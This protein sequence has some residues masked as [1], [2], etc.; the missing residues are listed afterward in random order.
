MKKHHSLTRIVL[1]LSL[2]LL[3]YATPY[4]GGSG[5]AEDPYQI[6]TPEQM[7]AIG[8]NNID[9]SQHFIL[10]EDIDMSAYTGSDY[11][12][13]GNSSTKFTGT[14]DG[15]GHVILNLTYESVGFE[16][17][18]GLFGYTK[19]ATI[20][21]LGLENVTFNTQADYTGGLV[22]YQNNGI[23]YNCD[24]T[25]TI[26]S[27][28]ITGGLVGLLAG[29]SVTNC[30]NSASVT[31]LSSENTCYAGGIAG[32]VTG[33]SVDHC[34]NTGQVVCE[35][36]T[37]TYAGGVTA[38][39]TGY[40]AHCHN[41][42]VINCTTTSTSPFIDY[43][44][45]AGGITGC[46][47]EGLVDNC[48]NTADV[49]SSAVSIAYAGGILGY[50]VGSWETRIAHCYSTASVSASAD[51]IYKGALVGY[52][53]S[54]S[55]I[56]GPCFWDTQTSGM[57]DGI[58]NLNPDPDT[59]TGLPT[60]AM[61][62]ASTFTAAGWNFI[63]SW[64]IPAGSYPLL[65][66]EK[67]AGGHG[68]TEEPYQIATAAQMDFLGCCPFDWNKHFLLI[69][70]LYMSAWTGTQYHIIGNKTTPFSGVFDGNDFTIS[71]LTYSTNADLDNVGLF[72]YIEYAE[73]HNLGLENVTI[74]TGGTNAG[75]LVGCQSY[76]SSV[77]HCYS[78]GTISSKAISGGLVGYLNASGS[79]YDCYS[80]GIVTAACSYN[81]YAGGIT[82]CQENGSITSCYSTADVFAS[83]SAV[84]PYYYSHAGGLVGYLASGTIDRC[85]SN[86]S[87]TSISD[88][89]RSYTYAGG[90]VGYQEN[91]LI[92]RCYS[93]G[94]VSCSS[95][96]THY[97]SYAGGMAGY[98][99]SG[100]IEC[101]YSNGPVT[102]SGSGTQ[103]AGGLCGYGGYVINSFWDT[104]TSGLNTSAG[105]C[106]RTTEQMRRL[107]N[108]ISWNTP[109]QVDWTIQEQI[110]TPRLNWEHHP[111]E[112]LRSQVFNDFVDGSGT[113]EDPYCISEPNQLA[114]IGLYKDEWNAVFQ[115]ENDIDLSELE[116]MD[117]HRIG[118]SPLHSFTGIFEGN[119][120][121]VHNLNYATSACTAY[122][123]LFGATHQATIQN[124][125]VENATISTG[126]AYAGLLIGHMASNSLIANC[127]GS[128]MVD[129]HVNSFDFSYAGGLVGYQYVS[130][131][132][133]SYSTA[134]VTAYSSK[135]Y[136]AAGGLVGQQECSTIS[137][138]YSISSVQA[139]ALSSLSA[140]SGGLTGAQYSSYTYFPSSKI[141]MSFSVGTVTAT[142]SRIYQGGFLGYRQKGSLSSC[143][144]DS[145]QCNLTDGVGNMDPD[146]SGVIGK[147]TVEMML[148]TT[149]TGWD[150][151]D[152]WM[153]LREGKDYPRLI[154][155][156]VFRG[157][158]AGLYGVDMTDLSYL[159]RYWELNDC[160]GTDDCGRADIDNSGDVGIGDL[161]AVTENWL[162]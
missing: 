5:T 59:A 16:F 129:S 48:Y 114:L 81:S 43:T 120:Y 4:G 118:V 154:W 110:D 115:L 82:G 50:R 148:E 141:E 37:S 9:W 41:T 71:N 158:I 156:E 11:N 149:F 152:S 146:P 108:Y 1:C 51:T 133:N 84:D 52:L 143:F 23:I 90:L 130:T 142:G 96:T 31:S 134:A 79:I 38:Q 117:F 111:G 25:G 27:V 103:I 107:S 113:T 91:G 97:R 145:Q 100:L 147:T 128:G 12:I 61:Q 42:G 126:G 58:G 94:A 140:C 39:N 89:T 101:C 98:Q 53:N 20:R 87:V 56:S 76:N 18:T 127:Y 160:G 80:D 69:T 124:F 122:T 104:Q 55:G 63:E 62:M 64:Y 72:G 30:Y 74:K 21:N 161:A 106:G 86:G 33:G 77:H 7:N 46:H 32:T 17:Y 36:T 19:N 93:T 95:I 54:Q 78:I 67:Y 73:I 85:C 131:I 28:R 57:T 34:Y 109:E 119:G 29:G 155:Q 162:Q 92:T 112:P 35:S 121:I 75:G 70:D 151:A 157:D 6:W 47:N 123:G 99:E 150:F 83:S 88:T 3:I 116:N 24:L 10:M 125:G 153:I 138:S 13:I 159:A 132:V 15:N 2:S 144:W 26:S 44:S 105:G 68:T 65:K 14:Y 102:T 8:L 45:Y 49:N 135:Q 22:G 40:I 60:S 137:E 139:V 136:A 66:W